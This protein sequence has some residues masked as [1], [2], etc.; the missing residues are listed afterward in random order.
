MTLHTLII[1]GFHLLTWLTSFSSER[2]VTKSYFKRFLFRMR[3]LI[4]LFK[5]KRGLPFSKWIGRIEILVEVQAN[6]KG[7]HCTA[8]GRES[9]IV[10]DQMYSSSNCNKSQHFDRIIF[11]LLFSIH[12]FTDNWLGWQILQQR[13]FSHLYRFVWWLWF[14]IG[15]VC[16]CGWKNIDVH[17]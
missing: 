17:A 2:P 1:L 3:Y 14:G 4:Y 15:L 10:V 16:N 9:K 12:Q 11:R 8:A 13:F 5:R 7:G 6:F